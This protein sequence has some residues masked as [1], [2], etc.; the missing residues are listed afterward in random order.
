M[1]QKTKSCHKQK[2][3][4]TLPELYINFVNYYLVNGYGCTTI[5][6]NIFNMTR[7]YDSETPDRRA[8]K[9]YC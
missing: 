6:G 3:L 7:L 4:R 9:R 2:Q 1:A 8:L 5:I